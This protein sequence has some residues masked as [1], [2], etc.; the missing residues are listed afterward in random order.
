M[1]H[2]FEDRLPDWSGGPNS[3]QSSHHIWN[4]ATAVGDKR[5]ILSQVAFGVRV[6]DWNFL[7]LSCFQLSLVSTAMMELFL[8][9]TTASSGCGEG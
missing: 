3:H 5:R 1:Q 8:L 9:V 4:S 2:P 6:P 7:R